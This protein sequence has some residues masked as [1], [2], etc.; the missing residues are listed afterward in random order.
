MD[1]LAL[2][3]LWYNDWHITNPAEPQAM[4]LS[5][6][7]SDGAVSSRMVLLKDYNEKGFVFFTNYNSL[8]SR[9]L[10]TN[11]KAALLFW[12]QPQGRQ[13]RIEGTVKK[14]SRET[15]LKYFHSRPRESQISAWA[16]EQSSE[17]PDR[18]Y[19]EKRFESLSEKFSGRDV[20]L[21]PYW[22]GL[23]LTPKRYEFWQEGPHRLHDRI[24]YLFEKGSWSCRRL[25][26]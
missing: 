16:S 12:W 10:T 2:F 26:P 6:A 1:P 13:V 14:V 9:Q 23:L 20:D 5:T 3:T 24:I 19:L 11:K 4:V 17:I 25:A 21:P 15:S 7:G 8:K 18:R 22:G